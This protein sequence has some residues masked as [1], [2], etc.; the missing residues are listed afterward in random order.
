MGEDAADFHGECPACH[1][2][3]QAREE[4]MTDNQIDT[5]KKTQGICN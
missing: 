4:H 3:Y 2:N 1:E 5:G